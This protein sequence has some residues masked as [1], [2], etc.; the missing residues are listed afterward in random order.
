MPPHAGQ[1]VSDTVVTVVIAGG[2]SKK[3]VFGVAIVEVTVADMTTWGGYTNVC[4]TLE[5]GH[6]VRGGV[7][8]NSLL[9]LAVAMS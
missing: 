8:S 5:K 4:F 7:R 6:E 1:C 2:I 9:M 3:A